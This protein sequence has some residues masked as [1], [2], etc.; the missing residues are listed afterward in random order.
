MYKLLVV[1]DEPA[2]R[3]VFK[4]LLEDRG[5]EVYLAEDGH[6][7]LSIFHTRSPEIVF[8]DLSLPRGMTGK[9]VLKEIRK[10]NSRTAVVIITGS[11][12]EDAQSIIGQLNVQ[13]ILKKPF[14]LDYV[15]K[16]I[17]PKIK[18]KLRSQQDLDDF[19]TAP[20]ADPEF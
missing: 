17:L 10:S 3:D 8:L 5:F 18:E 20:G 6:E 14:R 9:D 7:A 1:E 13:Y 16:Q 19:R 2:I 12:E 15:E 11:S 4:Y